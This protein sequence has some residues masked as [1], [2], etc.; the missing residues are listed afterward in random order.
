MAA[1]KVKTIRY[2]Q[3]RKIASE[4]AAQSYTSHWNGSLDLIYDLVCNFALRSRQIAGRFRPALVSFYP[5][6]LASARVPLQ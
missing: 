1:V 5:A 3:K 2:T 6:A 4:N